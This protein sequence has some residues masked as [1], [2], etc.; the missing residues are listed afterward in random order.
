MYRM[1][2][3]GQGDRIARATVDVF[4]HGTPGERYTILK[5]SVYSTILAMAKATTP[6]YEDLGDYIRKL[7]HGPVKDRV[8]EMFSNATQAAMA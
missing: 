8:M 6:D 5:N 1:I 7:D 2:R 3:Y 4:L